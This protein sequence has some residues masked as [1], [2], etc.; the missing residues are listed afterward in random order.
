MRAAV[1]ALETALASADAARLAPR[2][3]HLADYS[4]RFDTGRPV[5]S[6]PVPRPTQRGSW[7]LAQTLQEL[8]LRGSRVDISSRGL[9]LRHAH[10]L[11]ALAE[12]VDAHAA[13]VRLWIGLG[14]PTPSC[15]WDD[16]TALSLAWLR[17]WSAPA[18]PIPLRPGVAFT[19]W[20]RF[21]AS[22][23]G[24]AAEGAQAAC[25][26]GLRRDLADLFER[27]ATA[28]GV[29]LVRTRTARAA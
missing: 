10:R 8:R 24:R 5:L 17:Q 12:A 4:F 29:R 27:H 2:A 28:L 14:Q 11:L 3:D 9:R 25:A 15:G 1:P 16:A 13:A 18:G 26:D 21:V 20:P 22:V 7:T 23:E 6:H 19:D